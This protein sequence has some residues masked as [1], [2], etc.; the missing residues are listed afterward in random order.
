[1]K[2]S[3]PAALLLTAS[4]HLWAQGAGA[5]EVVPVRGNIYMVV[6]A[7]SNIVVS[8]GEDGG[9]LVDSGSAQMSDQVL[10]AINR[11][12]SDLNTAGRPVNSAAPPKPIRYIANTTSLPD[13]T[14]GN[15]KL[16]RAGK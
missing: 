5:L 2:R 3:I 6:G 10:A 8:A 11:L 7:G 12:T 13:H 1:M 15:E 9:F 16:A 4:A 14:G